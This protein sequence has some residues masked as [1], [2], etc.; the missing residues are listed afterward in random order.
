MAITV[1]L[2]HALNVPTGSKARPWSLS[3][4]ESVKAHGA[5]AGFEIDGGPLIFPAPLVGLEGLEAFIGMAIG[6]KTAVTH[7]RRYVAADAWKT[8]TAP[9]ATLS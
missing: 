9:V 3:G 2:D 4:G 1:A 5:P 7:G 8:S 6:T